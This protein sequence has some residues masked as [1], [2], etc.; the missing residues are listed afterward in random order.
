MKIVDISRID[1][2]DDSLRIRLTAAT[3]GAKRKSYY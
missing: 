1:S 2:C 3:R